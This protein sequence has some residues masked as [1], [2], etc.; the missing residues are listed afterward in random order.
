MLVTALG[1]LLAALLFTLFAVAVS[2]GWRPLRRLDQRVADG[3]HGDF[4]GHATVVSVLRVVT[5]AGS[6]AT[7]LAVLVVVALWF[8]ARRRAGV[9]TTALVVGGLVAAALVAG[10]IE[11]VIK[12]V[13][14]RPRPTFAHPLG[15]A[16]GYS[17]PSGHAVD[18]L[19]DYGLLLVV[20][21]P[22]LGRRVR[23]LAV[24]GAALWLAA[25]GFSRLGL[26]V[27]YLSDVVGGWLLGLSWLA[28]C[29]GLYLAGQRAVG[30]APGTE[31]A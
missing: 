5:D 2:G 13:V 15:H 28:A 1:G 31:S 18:S 10:G 29:S 25:V 7:S 8:V 26:G 30:R 19:V 11:R 24:T 6:P 21:L 17:F 14:G 12:Y 22:G 23:M 9:R 16:A 20:L 4:V 3:L 27:H